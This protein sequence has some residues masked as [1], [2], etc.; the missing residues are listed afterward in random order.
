MGRSN[1]GLAEL[2]QKY[3]TEVVI[4]FTAHAH[5]G[6]ELWGQPGPSP[7]MRERCVGETHA[8]PN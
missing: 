3:A 6:P 5:N 2:M 1:R 8:P 4:R 7:L